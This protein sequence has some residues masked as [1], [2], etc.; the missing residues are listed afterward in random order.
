MRSVS[1]IYRYFAPMILR[2]GKRKRDAKQAHTLSKLA[3]MRLRAPKAVPLAQK[4]FYPQ[5]THATHS[6]TTTRWVEYSIHTGSP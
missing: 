5:Q 2:K 3:F 4:H 6:P 1:R